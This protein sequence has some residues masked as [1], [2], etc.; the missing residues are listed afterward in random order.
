MTPEQLHRGMGLLEI[1]D[2]PPTLPQFI[3]LCKPALDP[4]VAYFE[5]IAGIAAREH[6]EVGQWSDPAI[7]W[8]TAAIGAF[9]LKTLPYR[10]I[11]RRWIAAL[12]ESQAAH[13]TEPIPAPE[14]KQPITEEESE[15]E[16]AHQNTTERVASGKAV[17]VARSTSSR[18]DHKRWARRIQERIARGDKTVTKNQARAAKEALREKQ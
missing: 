3:K 11:R 1:L 17:E 16:A 13:H 10:Q 14:A 18:P 6:G 5:A 4:Q 12:A 7:Y 2:L 8:A 15:A 9:D